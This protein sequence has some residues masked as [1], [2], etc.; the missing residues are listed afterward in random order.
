L[1]RRQVLRGVLVAAAVLCVVFAVFVW[2]NINSDLSAE[3]FE[4]EG[5]DFARYVWVEIN[6]MLLALLIAGLALLI[7]FREK[8]LSWRARPRNQGV[9]HDRPT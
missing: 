5:L 4:G 8:L 7:A 9:D 6:L 3:N 1:T 2:W